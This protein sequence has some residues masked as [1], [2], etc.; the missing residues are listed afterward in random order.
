M[1][2]AFLITLALT[3][4]MTGVIWGMQVLEYPLFALVGPAEFPAY[5]ARHNRGL[6]LVVIIPSLGAFVS[7]I[8]LIFA[9]PARIPLW[10]TVVIAALDLAIIIITVAREAPLHARL[11]R[12]GYM[13]ATIRQLVN[14]NW[15][16]TILWTANA[17][18]ILVL[19]VQVFTA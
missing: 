1:M 13:L 12:N 7:A 8:V 18:L 19:S 17:L 6:P 11:D 16:R 14:G 3:L 10:S 15:V 9:H 2:L 5:H 4:Y